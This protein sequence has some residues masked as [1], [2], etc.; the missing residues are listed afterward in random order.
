MM[1][2]S[3]L[4]LTH[5][6][7]HSLQQ[8]LQ[9]LT[10]AHNQVSTGKRINRP[11][12]DVGGT[13]RALALRSRLGADQQ[14]VRNAD[15]GLAWI[16]LTDTALQS[17]SDRLHRLRELAIRGANPTG[18]TDALALAEEVAGLRDELVS[19]ANTKHRGRGL[20]A[21]TAGGD[22]VTR[23][24]G[25]WTYT[26]NAGTTTRRIDEDTSVTVNVTADD[27]FGFSTG[28][29]LFSAL[30]TLEAR[31]LAGD[32]AAVSTSLDDLDRGLD[33]VLT[34]LARVGTTA[35]RIEAA[36]ERID[37][38]IIDLR[39]QLSGIEDADMAAAVVELQ[40]SQTAYQAVLQALG[41][42]LQT[43]ATRFLG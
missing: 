18:S 24:A 36:R 23:V 42:V 12:D 31:L 17:V 28:D 13:S 22:A 5:S 7:M 29:D 20:V 41:T 39:A 15:D 4:G 37:E 30:D 9:A 33:R 34:G 32:S 43:S 6:T 35:N 3:D 40:M 8:R 16:G 21:G 19:I 27:V 26:G 2:V 38:G 10:G 1:R 25:T 11:S 14:A